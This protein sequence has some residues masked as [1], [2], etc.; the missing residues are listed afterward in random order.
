MIW[1]IS[2]LLIAGAGVGGHYLYNLFFEV[3]A[4][5]KEQKGYEQGSG[6]VTKEQR[7]ILPF[8]KLKVSGSFNVF[9]L[10]GETESVEVEID[11]N[12]QQYVRFRNEGNKMFLDTKDSLDFSKTTRKNV[13]ITLKNLDVLEAS[14]RCKIRPSGSLKG[15]QLT[16]T[17]SG[18]T[19]VEL[20]LY[21]NQLNVSISGSAHMKLH[22]ET[23]A[24]DIKKSGTGHYDSMNLKAA[25]V[26]V[27]NRGIG[28]VSVYA[29]QE[30][31]MT[32][33]GIGSITYSGDAE[34]KT[35]EA[36]GVG[37]IKKKK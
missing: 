20:E 15:N 14:G 10:Q 11:D 31:S 36:S 24:L 23:E 8:D 28:S 34:I 2:G 13:Y 1:I 29:S 30:L 26:I 33:S 6:T 17:G 25:K 9:L 4:I 3:N 35:R 19:N 27:N 5:N 18:A 22:G 12:L 32:N 16:I 21:Y 7:E 37:S